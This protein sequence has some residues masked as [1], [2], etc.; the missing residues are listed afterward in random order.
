VVDSYRLHCWPFNWGSLAE[1]LNTTGTSTCLL[2]KKFKPSKWGII[3]ALIISGAL[4]LFIND[5]VVPGLPTLAGY[6]EL[7]FV[8]TL[9]LFFGSG[10]IVFALVLI[11]ILIYG[12]RITQRRNIHF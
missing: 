8:N 6:F 12:I 1:S 11:S 2:F 5:L 9:G 3:S 10:A 7:F 4:V